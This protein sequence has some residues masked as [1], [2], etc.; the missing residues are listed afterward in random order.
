MSEEFHS[1]QRARIVRVKVE[2]TKSG[3]FV[4]TS[5][6]LRG[7]LVA[8]NTV[9][10]L[11]EAVPQHIRDLFAVQGIDVVVAPA[12]DEDEVY[13]PWVAMSAAVAQKALAMAG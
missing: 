6:D 9:D 12:K 8:E 7:L 2:Q 3:L 4:A 11:Y 1:E 13:R 5:P 10:A